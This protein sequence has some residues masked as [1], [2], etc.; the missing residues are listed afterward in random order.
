MTTDLDAIV[1]GAGPNGLAAALTLARAGRSVRVYEG[2]STIG[3]GTRTEELTLPGFRHDVCSS[4]LPLTLASPFLRMVDFAA[5]G[6]E[7]I[8]P[9]APLAHALDGGRAAVLERSFTATAAGL[10][11][12][13][14]TDDGGAWLRLF[15]PLARDARKLSRELLGPVIHVPRHPLALARFGL[16]ALRSG[17]SLARSRFRGEPAR[18]LFG[19]LSAHSMVAIDRP[20]SAAFGLV[21][22]M[23]AH[24]VGWPMVRGGSAAVTHALAAELQGHGG[25]IVTGELV[26]DLDDLPPARVV[27]FDTT[28]RAMVA[29]A[30]GRLPPRT[31][32]RYEAF[33]YGSGVFKVDWA[34]DGPIPWTA[35]GLRR[36]GT[37]HLGGTLD[38]IARSESDVA[39]GRHSERPFTLVA[40]YHPWDPSRAPAGKTTAWAYCHVPS[41]SDVDMTARI[42]AQ[43]ER[44]APGFHDLVLARATHSPARLEA[45]DPNY[46]GGD[47]NAGIADIRQTLFRPVPSLDP[48]HAGPG[49]YLC[50]SSTPPG[51]GVH[52]MSGFLAAQSALRRD[53]R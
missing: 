40:Q 51:G 29:I 45:H 41:G 27:L 31:R 53:L 8:H 36:A 33:R 5:H 1:V 10:D 13:R 7:F 19:A 24:A 38:E 21:L 46:I 17:E 23:Y 48:Y 9:V 18:A 32:R 22:G 26:G 37:V 4:I 15:G 50:S 43:L 30:G 2:A 25:Q 3:G 39:A 28:P 16:P 20:L 6:V 34:L 42:E 49:L 44:F 47:I 52:G 14:R 11:H 35:D 12:D